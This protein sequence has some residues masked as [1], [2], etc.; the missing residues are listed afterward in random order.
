MKK[1][2]TKWIRGKNEK[3]KIVYNFACVSIINKCIAW[4]ETTCFIVQSIDFSIAK[5]CYIFM[6]D[7]LHFISMLLLFLFLLHGILLAWQVYF[8]I[9]LNIQ[10]QT[11]SR[12]TAEVWLAT[13]MTL[14]CWLFIVYYAYQMYVCFNL[15]PFHCELVEYWKKLISISWCVCMISISCNPQY[16]QSNSILN[17]E[18][19]SFLAVLLYETFLK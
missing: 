6:C 16:N 12:Y 7:V 18:N 8:P 1:K 14:L 11:S 15:L 9:A 4:S 10:L 17:Q 19:F 3:K 2:H 5:V 13:S